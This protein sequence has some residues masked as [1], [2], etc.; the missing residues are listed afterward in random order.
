MRHNVNPSAVAANRE[1]FDIFMTRANALVAQQ[2]QQQQPQSTTATTSNKNS[3]A[4]TGLST[5]TAT[6]SR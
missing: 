4:A 2:Q 3:E 5:N 6:D 1:I